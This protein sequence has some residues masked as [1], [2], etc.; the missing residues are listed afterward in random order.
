MRKFPL[1][2]AALLLVSPAAFANTQYNNT[3]NVNSSGFPFGSP[4]TANYGE[5]FSAPVTDTSLNDFSLFL[6]SGATG[7]LEGYIGTW[8]GSEAGSILYTSAPVTATG[9]IQEFTFDTSGLPLIAGDE[10]VAFISISGPG[11]NSFSGA[12]SMPLAP[13]NGSIPGGGWVYINNGSNTSLFTTG[14]SWADL[15]GIY[16]AAFVA[17]FGGGSPVPEPSSLLLLGTGLVG[18]AGALRRKLAR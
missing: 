17:D 10:Y 1:V 12:T 13:A 11:Y 9:S 16:D 15:G 5:T 8:A 4:N 7:P 18:L 14:D 6:N 2:L 3:S